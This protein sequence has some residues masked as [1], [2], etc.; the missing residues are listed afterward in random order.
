MPKLTVSNPDR[1]IYPDA[2]YTK[3]D[4]VAHYERVADSMLPHVTGRPLTLE[5]FPKGIGAKGFFQKNAGRHFPSFIE[6]IELPKQGGVTQHPAVSTV[7]GLVYLANQ[8]TIAFHIPLG[9]APDLRC[10]D[11][12]VFD[13]DPPEGGFEAARSAA[14]AAKELL[15]SLSV[16]SVP[17]V[18]GSKGYHVVVALTPTVRSD[19]VVET[20]RK[21]AA[22]MVRRHPD[23]LTEAFRIERREGRVFVDWI[24]NGFGATVI[25]PWSLRPRPRASVAVPISWNEL[26][27]TPPDA[28]V[29]PDIEERLKLGDPLIALEA[30]DPAELATAATAMADEL[31][32]VLEPFDR[33]RS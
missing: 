20:A 1:I 2:A 26:D 10:P 7:E 18:T 17:L 33:F 25:A 12:M 29:L 24:R 21:L 16:P 30:T 22:V 13:F 11:R 9:R 15:D 31:E 5:R 27:A 32:I 4:V 28:F 23:A 6:R 14:W 19:V 3:G 8:G